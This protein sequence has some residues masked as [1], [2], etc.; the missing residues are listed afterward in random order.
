MADHRDEDQGIF[1][2]QWSDDVAPYIPRLKICSEDEDLAEHE[3]P[4]SQDKRLADQLL[5]YM[6][7]K[8]KRPRPDLGSELT[9]SAYRST[10]PNEIRVLKLAPGSRH[11]PLVA[12]LELIDLEFKYTWNGGRSRT[13]FGLSFEKKKVAYT[14]ISYVWG[15]QRPTR[16]LMLS[17]HEVLITPTLDEILRSLR[18]S[19]RPITLW[20]DQLCIDQKSDADKRSQVKL[21]GLIYSRARNTIIWLGPEPGKDAFNA[22]KRLSLGTIGPRLGREDLLDEE[23]EKLRYPQGEDPKAMKNLRMLLR[24]AWFQRTWIVQE[25]VLSW[26]PHIMAGGDTISWQDFSG[27]CISIDKLGILDDE[28]ADRDNEIGGRRSGLALVVEIDTARH[29]YFNLSGSMNMFGWLVDTR[30]AGVTNPLD[31]VYGILGLCIDGVEPDYGKP[32]E[33]LFCK[34]GLKF[35]QDGI[36]QMEQHKITRV[37]ICID[38]DTDVTKY[39]LPS[40]VPDWSQPRLTIPLAYKTSSLAIYRAGGELHDQIVFSVDAD[41]MILR[42]PAIP[43]SNVVYTSE[44]F[45]NLELTLTDSSTSNPSLRQCINFFSLCQF[46]APKSQP[47]GNF[48]HTFCATLVAG[49][50]N[51]GNKMPADYIEILSFLCDQTSG[52]SPTFPGQT[53]TPR[54]KKPEGRG[55]LTSDHFKK[56]KSGRMFKALNVAYRN[57]LLNR[58]LCWT[59]TQ[60]VVLAPR[61]T[62][63]G[64]SIS[65]IPGCDVPFVLRGIGGDNY[66]VV[67]ECYADL[68]TDGTWISQSPSNALREISIV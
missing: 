68:L 12:T 40:W 16:S 61:F 47:D 56:G 5:Q 44:T 37:L 57:A 52:Q 20:A 23:L 54:Q 11:E 24:K 19:D 64:D 28:P 3:F 25:V 1:Y 48:W 8:T 36:D 21:M 55:R 32:V 53:Y 38:H 41:N 63:E 67:G 34:V 26:E 27:Y 62:R 13:W 35:V 2:E 60:D 4:G 43:V 30:H 49:K 14:A 17:G 31:K 6:Q 15:D 7:Q 22:L 65:I 58:R 45:S 18:K 46:S 39:R 42:A 33:E 29:Y 51:S 66:K 9:S 50:D 59:D 10:G